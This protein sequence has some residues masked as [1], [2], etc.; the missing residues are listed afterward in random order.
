MVDPLHVVRHV[1]VRKVM[2]RVPEPSNFAIDQN[3]FVRIG[4]APS[5]TLTTEQSHIVIRIP[6]TPPPPTVQIKHQT[7]QRK[8]RI[9]LL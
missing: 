1:P 3:L 6:T 2:E 4:A 8:S 9:V 7:R 5:S